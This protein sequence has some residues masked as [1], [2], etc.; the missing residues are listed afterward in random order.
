MDLIFLYTYIYGEFPLDNVFPI[1][2]RV[3]EILIGR[4]LITCN[5]MEE[6]FHT[7]S[8]DCLIATFAMSIK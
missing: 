4:L 8:H 6:L 1:F 3:T 2:C 7:T 5:G